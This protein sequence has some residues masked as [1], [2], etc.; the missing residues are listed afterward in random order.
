LVAAFFGPQTRV[1][2]FG[3][4]WTA[5]FSL[6]EKSARV[7]LKPVAFRMRSISLLA[8][9]FVLVPAVAHAQAAEPAPAAAA[10]TNTAATD[11][12]PVD[13]HFSSAE[14]GV[15]VYARPVPPERLTGTGAAQDEPAFQA[16]CQAPCDVKLEPALHEFAVAPA[17]SEP[18]PAAPAFELRSDARFR[19]DVISHES[20]RRAGW[21]IFG[22]MGTVGIT[23]T[24]IGMFQ[25]CVDDQSCQEWTSLAIW[26]GVAITTAGTLLGLPM[27]MTS[28]EATL[29]LVP[30][31]APLADPAR[32]RP[33]D[34]QQA[35]AVPGGATFV[36]RF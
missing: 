19:A 18:I 22:I 35:S 3:P 2:A 9:L 12:V 30:G 29:T 26:S 27:I 4:P 1:Q 23:T 6:D 21:W 34:A 8:P 11:A 36:G 28:D 14:P 31:T 25:T 33:P 32:V 10:A 20:K 17:G 5:I 7:P 15:T 13:V 16:I 24:T